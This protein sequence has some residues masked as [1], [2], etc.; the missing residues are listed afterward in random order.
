MREP[1]GFDRRAFFF[2]LHGHGA[3]RALISTEMTDAIASHY[4]RRA[5]DHG[6]AG[7]A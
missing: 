5:P 1:A 3:S 7:F 6:E 2:P 4:P